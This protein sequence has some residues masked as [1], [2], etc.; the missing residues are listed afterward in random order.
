MATILIT[1]SNAGLGK[2]IAL[3]LTRNGHMVYG[4][5]IVDKRD[6]RHPDAEFINRIDT[7]SGGGIDV[8][9]N[10][11]GINKINWLE[12]VTEQEYDDVMDTNAK[13]IFKMT[14]ACLPQLIKSK[15]TILNIISNAAH[16]PMRCSLAYNASKGAAH[17]MTKQLARELTPKYGITVFGVAPNR[18]AGTEMS[19][20]IDQQVIETRGWTVEEAQKYQNAALLV[21]EETPPD[22]VAGFISY[23]LN[24][25][26]NHKF[27]TGCILPYGI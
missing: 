8:L 9:I 11:A 17:I 12:D 1:G 27:L 20:A 18:I 22:A 4:Y 23:L 13:S 3:S 10:N 2:C 6:V 25:K 5:D 7:V 26:E 24:Q 21:G 16:M 19:N 15:G 14:Q